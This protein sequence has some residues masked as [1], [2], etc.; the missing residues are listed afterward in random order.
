MSLFPE[1]ERYIVAQ[2][3]LMTFGGGN[4]AQLYRILGQG[5]TKSK[6]LNLP[7]AEIERK[8]ELVA[9]KPLQNPDLPAVVLS[10]VKAVQ[11]SLET[12]LASLK[13]ADVQK[14]LANQVLRSLV[15]VKSGI[16]DNQFYAGRLILGTDKAGVKWSWSLTPY[17]PI[18]ANIPPDLVYLENA[19]MAAESLLDELIMP[20]EI[21]ETRLNL[22]WTLARHFSLGERVL[23]IDVARMYKIAGQSEKFWNVPQKST[24]ADIPD[25]AFI[26]NLIHWMKQPGDKKSY[27]FVQA[28][29]HQAHGKNAKVYYLPSN[30][31]AT[32]TRPVVYIE[33]KS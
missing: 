15:G 7:P 1:V 4:Q 22:A 30:A 13:K 33:K 6:E 21:F 16:K 23:I 2:K 32:I 11:A 27:S 24:F 19:Y 25:G 8:M 3:M 5:Q 28:T 9:C 20:S 10:E 29:L 26:A 14:R 31:E 17:Y 12:E 18:I